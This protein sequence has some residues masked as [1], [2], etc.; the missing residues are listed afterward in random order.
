MRRCLHD[1]S[2]RPLLFIR[3]DGTPTCHRQT[4]RHGAIA[5][6]VAVA[7]RRA[8]VTTQLMLMMTHWWKFGISN[9]VGKTSTMRIKVLFRWPAQQTGSTIGP[10]ELWVR[11][12]TL[13][14]P[15]VC[16]GSCATSC[17]SHLSPPPPALGWQRLKMFVHST[18]QLSAVA[19]RPARRNRA[20]DRSPRLVW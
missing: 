12:Q 3:F 5:Y 19:N 10:G 20:V 15:A 14:D 1:D 11:S 17:W 4:R 16:N 18:Q 2:Y 8:V 7:Q 13:P 9:N 6:A